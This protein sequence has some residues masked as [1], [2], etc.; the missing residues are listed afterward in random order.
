MG[1]RYLYNGFRFLGV[2]MPKN[3]RVLYIIWSLFIN[4]LVTVYLPV[5]F[6]MSFT[7]LSGAELEIGNVLTSL[8]VAINVLGCSIKI[9]LMGFL[10]PKLLSCSP[11]IEKL[12]KRCH[13]K[14]EIDTIKKFIKEGNRFVVL[15]SI[16]YW[17]YSS[18]TCV[19]ALAFHRL[20]YNI[21][22]PLIDSKI[23]NL[24]FYAAVFVEM[25]LL[26]V[27]CFQQVVDDSYAVIYVSILRTHLEILLKRIKNMNKNANISLQENFDELKMCIIDHKNIIQ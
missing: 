13:T 20:P 23:S 3:N 4:L 14:E 1:L 17:T 8:Q 7:K 2:Y 12:D 10:L 26:D 6:A 11:I 24:H 9:I 27:A 19:S 25:A 5:G 22:N 16:S 21:W 18:S 15:F